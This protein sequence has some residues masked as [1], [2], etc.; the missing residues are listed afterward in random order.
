MVVLVCVQLTTYYLFTK[1]NLIYSI[2]NHY[3]TFIFSSGNK[4]EEIM[5]GAN[6][7]LQEEKV[8]VSFPV[9][10]EY[11]IRLC[12]ELPKKCID[13]YDWNKKGGINIFLK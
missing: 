9:F 3:E 5:I 10:E 6:V 8:I 13:D 12:E 1:S 11:V 2:G 4:F 7:P